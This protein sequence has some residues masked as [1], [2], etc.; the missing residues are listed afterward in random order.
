MINLIH[1]LSAFLISLI[2][3]FL[4]Y[5][6]VSNKLKIK[7]VEIL[8]V[9]GSIISL[10][11]LFL[12]T[13]N[14]Y[15]TNKNNRITTIGNFR[16]HFSNNMENI[17]DILNHDDIKQLKNEIIYGIQEN[18]LEETQINEKEFLAIFKIL[19]IMDNLYLRL[20]EEQELFDR[21]YDLN[22]YYKLL[23]KIVNSNKILHLWN[24]E[25]HIFHKEFI[26]FVETEIKNEK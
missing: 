3:I 24:Q 23:I 11:S 6:E 1:I 13:Y 20:L 18:K 12:V 17:I 5:I 22:T 14:N 2:I 7:I 9:F 8:K 25:K 4:I 19:I 26:I 15:I 16:N 10:L 21:Q